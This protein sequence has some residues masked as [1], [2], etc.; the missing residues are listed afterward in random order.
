MIPI[1]HML[2]GK[3]VKLCTI[4]ESWISFARGKRFDASYW[5]K[6]TDAMRE[7]DYDTATITDEDAHF[8]ITFVDARIQRDHDRAK[9]LRKAAKLMVAEARKLEAV[10]FIK[11][12]PRAKA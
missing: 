3:P 2:A 5:V 9:E 8:V 12:R 11:G 4:K 6:V 10:S 1:Y 7:C